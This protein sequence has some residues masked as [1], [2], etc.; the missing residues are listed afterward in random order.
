MANLIAEW[1]E[2]ETLKFEG[3][4]FSHLKNRKI[5]EKLPWNYNTLAKNLVKK[6]DSVLDMGTGGGKIF[7]SFAPFNNKAKVSPNS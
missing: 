2:E 4:D 6:S 7:S 1:K 5:D 3:W